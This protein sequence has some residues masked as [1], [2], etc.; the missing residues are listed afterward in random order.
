MPT[1]TLT[2]TQEFDTAFFHLTRME[3]GTIVSSTSTSI[4][5][6]LGGIT[7]FLTGTNFTTTVI[8]GKTFINGGRVTGIL[9]DEAGEI[10]CEATGLSIAGSTLRNA[11]R[12][13][14][15]GTSN[16]AM[17]NLF[18][19]LT[20]TLDASPMGGRITGGGNGSTPPLSHEGVS[21]ELTKNNTWITGTFNEAEIYGGRGNDTIYGSDLANVYYNVNF[22]SGRAGNDVLFGGA[23]DDYLYG[24]TGNDSL[25][26]GG[27]SNYLEG[28][29]GPTCSMSAT[30]ARHP[31]GPAT[32]RSMAVG[33][34]VMAMP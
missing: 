5:I 13:D 26:G 1:L 32:T 14:F 2:A 8:N 34:T 18:R 27:G 24:G 9:V 4:E 11:M 23:A 17:E 19:N 10:L 20:W 7:Y 31:G 15:A 16:A 6:S 30:P 12:D 28:G 33:S 3:E 22:L 21:M 25:Y 29:P